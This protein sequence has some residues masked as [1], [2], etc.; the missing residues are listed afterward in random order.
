MEASSV[1]NLCGSFVTKLRVTK[2]MV[3]VTPRCSV[4]F[5]R[6]G[7]LGLP[8][9]TRVVLSVAM[10]PLGIILIT[11]REFVSGRFRSVH[12]WRLGDRSVTGGPGALTERSQNVMQNVPAS[13]V[14]DH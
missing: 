7:L 14:E 1:G 8:S 11:H 6:G 2:L 3:C 4:C 12:C 9:A 5:G 10:Y 13:R